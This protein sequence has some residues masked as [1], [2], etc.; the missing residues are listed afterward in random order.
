VAE[1]LECPE[2]RAATTDK[3]C[4]SETFRYT[5]C[6]LPPAVPIEW[7]CIHEHVSAALV[8]P[9]HWQAIQNAPQWYC[10]ACNQ[11]GHDCPVIVRE[12]PHA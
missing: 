9:A 1:L 11:R 10:D 3:P 5:P 2:V 8:C 12:V 7:G 4:R 6:D